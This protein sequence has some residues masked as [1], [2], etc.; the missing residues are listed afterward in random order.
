[1]FIIILEFKTI[2]VLHHQSSNS[3]IIIKIPPKYLLYVSCK[4]YIVAE[5]DDEI[6]T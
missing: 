5:V 6:E 1:M 4:K 2:I 3:A